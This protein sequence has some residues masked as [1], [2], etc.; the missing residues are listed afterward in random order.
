MGGPDLN[1]WGPSRPAAS[2]QRPQI[3]AFRQRA[4]DVRPI[5]KEEVLPVP[6]CEPAAKRL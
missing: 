1:L 6:L 2:R 3:G 4:A 5:A